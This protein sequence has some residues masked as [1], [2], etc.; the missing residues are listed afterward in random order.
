MDTHL[1]SVLKALTWRAAALS[2]TSLVAWIVT[3]RIEVALSV[4]VAD[5]AFKLLA[6]YAHE[7]LWARARLGKANGVRS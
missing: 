3:R 4:G 5:T 1:R 6:Y 2:I 7:R